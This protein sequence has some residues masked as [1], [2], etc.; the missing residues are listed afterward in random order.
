MT[1]FVVLLKMMYKI[2]TQ[3]SLRASAGDE[4]IQ[5]LYKPGLLRYARNDKEGR[6]AN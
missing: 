3:P 1:Y 2:T 6:N 5:M 4:A